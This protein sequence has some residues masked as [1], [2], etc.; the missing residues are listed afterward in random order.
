[1]NNVLSL[2][3]EFSSTGGLVLLALA[4]FALLVLR[5]VHSHRVLSKDVGEKPAYIQS[6]SEIV[7]SHRIN[8]GQAEKRKWLPC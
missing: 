1:M 5:R 4:V 3:K 6:Y 8:E 2:T 7:R